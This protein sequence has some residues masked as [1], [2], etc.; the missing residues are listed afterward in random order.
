MEST[1]KQY[2]IEKLTQ[3]LEMETP[4]L[5]LGAGFS[6]GAHNKFGSVPLSKNLKSIL[7]DKFYKGASDYKELEQMKLLDLCTNIVVDGNQKELQD[8]LTQIFVF[9][10]SRYRVCFLF[11]SI[12]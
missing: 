10:Y 6:C 1:E 2:S 4:I 5:L 11:F 3:I 8:F 9:Y 12:L 7:L